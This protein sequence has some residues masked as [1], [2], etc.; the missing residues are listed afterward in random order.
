MIF[1]DTVPGL[2][3]WEHPSP[4][5]MRR[6]GHAVVAAGRV[7]VIDPP[8]GEGVR[9]RIATLGEVAGVL[10]LLDRHPRDCE[11][12]AAHFGVPLH[13]TP[14]GEQLPGIELF[15]VVRNPV[16]KEVGA[17]IA[18]TRTLI[19]PESLSA[20]EAFIAPGEGV[21]VHPLRR[22]L[23]PTMVRRYAPE[24]LLTGHGPAVHGE[25]ACRAAISDALAGSRR[26]VPLLAVAQISRILRGQIR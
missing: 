9:E 3:S 5:F 8:D 21:G 7:W 15:Q 18:E 14:F 2:L 11:A 4:P 6:A 23:P 17:W 13:V 26:R 10:Q 22:L 25:A 20:A 1:D 16:W 19:V 24:H 12:L